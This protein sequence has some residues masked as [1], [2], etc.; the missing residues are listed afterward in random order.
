MNFLC[1]LQTK[2]SGI[3]LLFQKVFSTNIISVAQF[4]IFGLLITYWDTKNGITFLLP[5]SNDTKF[6]YSNM[7]MFDVNNT[8]CR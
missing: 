1:S 5:Y 7:R 6:F 4:S 2:I 8:C 3:K